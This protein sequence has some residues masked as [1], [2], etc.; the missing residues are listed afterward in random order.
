MN[1]SRLIEEALEER[2]NAVMVIGRPADGEQA[3]IQTANGPLGLIMGRPADSLV[4]LPLASLQDL[5][6]D[7][8]EW[9]AL[10]SALRN[11]IPLKLDLKLRVGGRE[12]WFGFGL[13]FKSGRETGEFSGEEGGGYGIV[14]GRDI[15]QSRRR[16]LQENESQRLLASV[17]MRTSAAVAIVAASGNIMMANPA[18]QRLLGYDTTEIVGLNVDTL[19]SD[20]FAAAARAARARQLLDGVSYDMRIE[21]LSKG[22]SRI[23]GMLSSTLLRDAQLQRMRVITLIPDPVT[24]AGAPHRELPAGSIPSELQHRSVG[25]LQAISLAALKAAAGDAWERIASRAMMLGEQ[26]VKRRLGS[27]DVFSR[28]DDHGFVIWFDSVDNAHNA[29]VLAGAA[30][31]IRLRFLT[32]LGD[33]VAASVT[34][35]MAREEAE[36]VGARDRS[37]RMVPSPALLDRLTKERQRDALEA[38]ALLVELRDAAVA[39]VRPVLDRDRKVRSGVLVDFAPPKRLRIFDL[40]TSIANA[41]EREA[42][43]DLLRLDLALRELVRRRGKGSVLVPISWPALTAFGRSRSIDERLA[44]LDPDLRSQLKLAVFDVPA[45]PNAKRWS[46]IIGPLRRQ[47]GEVGLMVTLA[48]G[49]VAAVQETIVADWPLSLLVIDATDL[50]S[51]APDGYFGL[52]GAARRRDIVVLVRAAAT[53]D[54]RD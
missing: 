3:R 33:E 27:A 37:M 31:E 48:E 32:E 7:P 8:A 9:A 24:N 11:L 1:L 10:M 42:D 17:F 38:K 19:V 15:T 44:R 54:I 43:I 41:P 40:A 5:A 6:E 50:A 53:G 28:S 46:E 13:T 34:A 35:A 25:Q 47:I 16:A 22:A 49:D 12:T 20:A 51:I 4:G 29:A 52:I 14:I 2:G 36:P 30:R 21:A 39:D 23:P 26:I 18:F 45:L